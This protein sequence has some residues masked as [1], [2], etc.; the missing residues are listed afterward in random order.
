MKFYDRQIDNVINGLVLFGS[1]DYEFAIKKLY[2]LIN[3][4]EF[5]RKLQ[6]KKF[7]K[8]L[9]RDICSGCVM[10]PIT[11]AMLDQDVGSLNNLTNQEIC[12]KVM[13]HIEHAF[14]L[15][16]IQ[17]LNTLESVK[18]QVNEKINLYFN[19]IFCD[20][21]EKLLYRMI[22]LNNGQRPMTPRHQVEAIIQNKM[23]SN[24]EQFGI[25]ILKEKDKKAI[26]ENF[27]TLKESDIIQAYL[28]F[29]SDSP[30]LDNKRIIEDKMDELIVGKI[31]S[32]D[33]SKY[34]EKFSD[35]IEVIGK[36]K[37]SSSAVKWFQNTNNLVGFTVGVKKI[38][39]ELKSYNM[40]SIEQLINNFEECFK[41]LKVSQI[42]VG[43]AR[44]ELSV[45][46]FGSIKNYS[47][48]YDEIAE[49][50]AEYE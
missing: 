42:K 24:Y 34:I 47:L 41:M 5:Q 7:Y 8:K 32:T 16:G 50:F 48:S 45:I 33:P 12:D 43:K 11:I 27:M 21:Q 13:E 15:D 2:P 17:R 23:L 18:D 46:V 26:S 1:V 37:D 9:A 10:P 38:V 30:L 28:S 22:T 40:N 39:S 4:T 49:I 25:K 20:S 36:L 35:V 31:I 14:I 3:K 19:F 44:R 29:L 6:D